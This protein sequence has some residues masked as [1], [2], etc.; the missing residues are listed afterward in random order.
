MRASK[1]ISRLFFPERC[2]LCKELIAIEQELCPNCRNDVMLISSD[3]CHHCG[4]DTDRCICSAEEVSLSHIGALSIYSGLTKA[5]IHEFKF[6]GRKDIGKDFAYEMSLRVGEIF[7][8]ADFDCVTFVP[9]TESSEKERGFNQSEL[10]A[11]NIAKSLFLPFDKLLVKNKETAKQHTVS[12]GERRINLKGAFSL[13]PCKDIRGKTVLLCDDVKTTGNTLKECESILL[14]N[15]AR[16][17][18]CICIA[19]SDYG[20]VFPALH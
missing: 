8:K 5:R 10:L 11:K 16:D 7:T 6:K 13:A 15:G 3:F 2:P 20:D 12:E 4:Y 1:F 19:L 17:V 18:Y 14:Q 9:M